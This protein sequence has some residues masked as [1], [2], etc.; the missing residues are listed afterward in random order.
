[1]STNNTELIIK[2]V[3]FCGDNLLLAKY[4]GK[5]YVAISYVCH[6]IGLTKG[7]T[8]RQV[9]KIQEDVVLKNSIK[10]LNV[11][12]DAQNRNVFCIELEYLPL[13][14]AKINANIIEDEYVQE[15][16]IAYQIQ[17]KDVL[18]KVFIDNKQFQIPQTY[19]EALR[20]A[21]VFAEQAEN[22][23]LLMSTENAKDMDEVVNILK[24]PKFGRTKIFRW[25]RQQGIL[26]DGV[27]KNIPYSQFSKYFEVIEIVKGK[28]SYSKT[29]VKPEG[30]NF[31]LKRIK[32]EKRLLEAAN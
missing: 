10:N 14:L 18:A 29:L 11:K 23:K 25:L 13:W 16:L 9:K 21:S 31:I 28:Q 8:D 15:K 4:D 12:N 2:E 22:Y 20:L 19:S 30:I 7:Q 17:A 24:I 1:M 6:G 27:R 32:K 3:N 5:V 26:M